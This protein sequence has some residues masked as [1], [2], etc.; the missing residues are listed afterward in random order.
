MHL[1]GSWRLRRAAT[2]TR[3]GGGCAHP[4]RAASRQ[5]KS[6]VAGNVSAADACALPLGWWGGRGGQLRHTLARTSPPAAHHC[7]AALRRGSTSQSARPATARPRTQ[8]ASLL[9]STRSRR[10]ICSSWAPCFWGMRS[11]AK[12]WSNGGVSLTWRAQQPPAAATA[13]AGR[14]QPCCSGRYQLGSWCA[15]TRAP[16]AT[17]RAASPTGPGACWRPRTTLWPSTSRPASPPC[18][19]RA[20]ASRWARQLQPWQ[21]GRLLI[22]GTRAIASR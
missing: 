21:A 10:R 11:R 16:S 7:G 13:P 20:T 9:A 14:R 5:G 15:S 3:G 2:A 1:V 17:L 19:T 12:P 8:P 4:R 6:A 22:R 18:G